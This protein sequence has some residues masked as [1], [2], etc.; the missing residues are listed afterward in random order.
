MTMRSQRIDRRLPDLFVELAHASTPDYLEA[1][2]E[3][4]SS[5]PQ[6]PSWTFPG[7]LLPVQITTRAVPAARMPWRQ[8]GILALICILVAA[9]AVAYVG[10]R[11]A[12]SPAPPFGRAANG[13]IALERDG[14]I[15]SVD[16][17][18]GAVTPI[19]S[20]PELDSAP[21]YS[22]D[23]A[24]IAFERRADGAADLPVIMVAAADGTGLVQATPE[25]LVGLLDWTLS[26]DGS[27]LL[28]SARHD[29]WPELQV[30]SVTGTR[31][32]TSIDMTLPADGDSVERASYRPPDGREILVVG[33]PA[34]SSTRG[35]YIA[36]AAT[37]ETLRTVVEPSPVDD[38][39]GASWSPTG[40]AIVYGRHE[41]NRADVRARLHVVSADGT[42][43]RLLSG[44]PGIAADRPRSDWSNDG[45][46]LVVVQGG[47]RAGTGGRVEIVPVNGGRAVEVWC[48]AGDSAACPAEDALGRV[49]WTWSPD[50]Q[51]LL[52]SL[53]LED[54]T[55]QYVIVDPS[56]GRITQTDWSGDG[57]PAWQRAKP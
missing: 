37:G 49:T 15:L 16:R 31:P 35:I 25:P 19:T 51:F 10:S 4:A 6:R 54:P 29:G 28:V 2:I 43:D 11:R 46:R 33:K 20:G 42:G 39:F 32:P 57:T 1:A 52:G 14:D 5:R 45:T 8:L 36:D 7:R 55:F 17:A 41:L 44:T 34:G 21:V 50:D 40:D 26:P 12:T 22:G 47:S 38:V 23:G 30:L 24:R 3:E 13:A 27:D 53:M 48:E 18:T 56:T 9:A